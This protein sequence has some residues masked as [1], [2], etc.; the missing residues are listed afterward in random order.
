MRIED[1]ERRTTSSSRAI[2]LA[3]TPLVQKSNTTAS[4]FC[5]I[6]KRERILCADD[7]CFGKKQ[8]LLPVGDGEEIQVTPNGFCRFPRNRVSV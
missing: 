4:T 6:T 8:L 3:L 1:G 2:L 5:Y 7:A